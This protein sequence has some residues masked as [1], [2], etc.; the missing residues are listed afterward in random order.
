MLHTLTMENTLIALRAKL[1]QGGLAAGLQFLNQR[2]PHRFTGV[3]LLKD[4]VLHNVELFDKRAE[5]PAEALLAVPL[6]SSFC[7]FVLRDGF[8]LIGDSG[9]D[10]R[11]NG[12][13]Y[14]GILNS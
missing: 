4:G 5:V 2:V 10:G 8:M 7:Q 13:P 12:H 11:L 6:T 14:Q 3:Y 1:D 9:K